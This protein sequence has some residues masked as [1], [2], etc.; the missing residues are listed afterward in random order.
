MAGSNE[1]T[2]ER[3]QWW[4][5]GVNVFI[6]DAG[7][8]DWRQV[9][10]YREEPSREALVLHRTLLLG[11]DEPRSYD[12][13]EGEARYRMERWSDGA[14]AVARAQHPWFAPSVGLDE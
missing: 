11:L 6:W 2:P 5:L 14:L 12:W 3:V 4:V 8:Q 10:T 1:P 13:R 9:T 7:R